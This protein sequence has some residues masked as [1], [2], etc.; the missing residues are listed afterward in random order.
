MYDDHE[1][2]PIER[3]Q[4]A[5]LPRRRE[6][7]RLLEERTVRALRSRGL[8]RRARTQR[9]WWVAAAAAAIAFFTTGYALG[10]RSGSLALVGT[11]VESQQ[12][13]AMQTALQVQRTGS[14]WIAALNALAELAEDADP[15]AVRQGRE[16]A[17]AA[18]H[19]A[20]AEFT[21]LAPG[22]PVA[23]RLVWLLSEPVSP[24]SE[25]APAQAVI[26]F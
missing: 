25:T 24:A 23:A 14:A 7:G 16:A 9:A 3:D 4:L 21:V 18:L 17:K 19:A 20:A 5:S 2:D 10:Q 22:D 15:D 11:V 8:L 26:W 13:A 6:P 12:Q 1:P